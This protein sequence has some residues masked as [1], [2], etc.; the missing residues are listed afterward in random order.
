MAELVL[1]LTDDE[2][3]ALAALAAGVAELAEHPVSDEQAVVAAIEHGLVRLMEDYEL[4]DATV[5]DRV[6]TAHA[7]LRRT[8]TRANACL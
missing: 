5:A 7:Q 1:N 8:W 3:R 4:P 2:R 6:G